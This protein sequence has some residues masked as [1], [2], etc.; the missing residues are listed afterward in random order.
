MIPSCGNRLHP[1]A[2]VRRTAHARSGAAA[3]VAC[4]LALGLGV[5][6][7]TA[8][9]GPKPKPQNLW[10]SYPLDPSH[11]QSP[12][13]TSDQPSPPAPTRT[14]ER[15]ARS[16][17]GGTGTS[18]DTSRLLAAIAVAMLL[19]GAVI[20]LALR[21]G[22]AAAALRGRDHL[23]LPRLHLKFPR[24]QGGFSMANARNKFGPRNEGEP[25]A[26]PQQEQPSQE[27][28]N[29]PTSA[30]ES[31]LEPDHDDRRAGPATEVPAGEA[32]RATASVS[33]VA[34][35]VGSVLKSAE[36]AAAKIRRHAEEEA[37]RI[38]ED[39]K[40]VLAEAG[41]YAE[42]TRTEADAYAKQVR[43]DAEREA[44][45]I[46]GHAQARLERVDAV[47]EARVRQAEQQARDRLEALQS[48]AERYRERLDSMLVVFRG[49]GSQLEELLADDR[50]A[51]GAEDP[52]AEER[53]E[54]IE[55]AL[56]PDGVSARED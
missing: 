32:T 26:D 44:E 10:N 49:M 37:G 29:R 39:A 34:A 2:P 11:K 52:E 40:R 17:S 21:P 22:L 30:G 24:T 55:D 41:S 7:P 43:E 56:Q 3:V 25:T 36:E 51:S 48:E 15:P 53:E 31:W 5:S 20:A 38:R 12:P 19:A 35:E 1:T 16:S 45:E 42:N 33:D 14:L 18:D 8:I 50:P 13:S 9:A 28:G 27:G 54:T 46:E 23:H 4:V 6:S 47:V